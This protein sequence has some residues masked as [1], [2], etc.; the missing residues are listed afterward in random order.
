MQNIKDLKASSAGKILVKDQFNI[1]TL[2]IDVSSAGKVQYENI[3]AK[4]PEFRALVAR[5]P[6]LEVQMY[7]S[8]KR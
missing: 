5:L 4:S 8:I 1:S 2:N 7:S 3:E 6:P